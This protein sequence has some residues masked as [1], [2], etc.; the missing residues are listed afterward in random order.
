MGE[1]PGVFACGGFAQA[2]DG[3]TGVSEH[4]VDSAV[5]GECFK[6]GFVG[7]GEDDQAGLQLRRGGEDLDGGIA[8]DDA[9]LDGEAGAGHGA[10]H[11]VHLLD[12]GAVKTCGQG[13]AMN[14]VKVGQDVEEDEPGV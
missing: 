10:R 4:F 7:G 11:V 9:G 1:G 2:E 6:G 13:H 3:A 14:L 8:V 5:A 12:G